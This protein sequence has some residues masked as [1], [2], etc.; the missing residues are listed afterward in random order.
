MKSRQRKKLLI[1]LL[2]LAFFGC[3][4]L[5]AQMNRLGS[6][7]LM[8][9]G[10]SKLTVSSFNGVLAALVSLVCV[11]IVCV[12][13]YKGYFVAIA[14][15][16]IHCLTMSMMII[17]GR[18]MGPLPGI[19]N[20]LITMIV[21]SLFRRSFL[22]REKVSMTDLLTGLQNLRGMKFELEAACH[23]KRKFYIMHIDLR[24]FKR[25]NEDLGHENG[26][27]VLK[28]VG[29]RIVKAIGRNAS[30]SR[31]SGDEFVALYFGHEEIEHV[32][33]RMIDG[34]NE[35][36]IVKTDSLC[37]EC[38]VTVAVG[39]ACYP[40]NADDVQ[41]L[42]KCAD[43]ALD[44]AKKSGDNKYHLYELEV[45]RDLVRQAELEK[46]IREGLDNDLFYM[47][48]QPQFDS[49]SQKL[50]GFESLVR[51]RLKNGTL[52]SPAEFISVAERSD[53]ILRVDEY[54]LRR[55]M[56]EFAEVM[57]ADTSGMTVSI[58][59]S[60]KNVS[61][62]GFADMICRVAKEEGFPLRNLE[63]EITEY[64]LVLDVH[65]VEENIGL[66][67]SM[68]VKL[69]LDDFGTGY[70]SL[71]YLSSF[72]FDLLKIDKCFVD[73]LCE[74]IKNRNFISAVI[75]IGHINGCEVLAEGVETTEELEILV[76]KGCD[77]IQG[78]LWSRPLSYEKALE[79]V[80]KSFAE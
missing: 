62:R 45:E 46:A 23:K 11:M 76:D 49:R 63:I 3:Y 43:I 16:L 68:G 40:E 27:K 31:I 24:S 12:D 18:D 26:D 44:Y 15:L 35:R 7:V 39:I 36:I 69:A 53:M 73:R 33:S 54:V 56:K 10:N 41:G 58:N 79:L 64:C 19:L 80:A 1:A 50:R 5:M 67:H 6:Q 9:I 2:C 14:L 65:T 8:E 70:A 30:V 60:A 21:I 74:G 75:Y 25:I 55:V 51:L 32:V 17:R 71:S 22:S 48:Y 28:V 52:I 13:P 47:D 38:F 57:R 29:E 77:Y 78:F 72:A 34:L 61:R 42:L 20:Q 66:L 4:I 59:V 37:H